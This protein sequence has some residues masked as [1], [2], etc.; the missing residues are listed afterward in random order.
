MPV[1]KEDVIS[2]YRFLLGREPAER[3][4]TQWLHIQSVSA[5]RDI[6]LSSPE[7]QGR[8]R[9]KMPSLKRDRLPLDIAPIVIEWETDP[10]T[11][12]RL[13]RYVTDT[14][15]ALGQTEPHWSVLSTDA[16]KAANIERTEAAFYASGKTDASRVVATLARHA[17]RTADLQRVVEYG[18]GVGRVTPYLAGHFN[19]V[20]GVDISES[21]LSLAQKA[22]SASGRRNIR[23]ALARAPDFGM[24]EPFD[25]WFSYIVLQHNPPPVI[26]L[27]LRRMF[28]MLAPGGV[29]IFQIPT[30]VPGYRFNVGKYLSAPKTGEIEVHCLPQPTVFQIAHDA[31]CEAL[32]VREDEAMDYPWLSNTFVFRKK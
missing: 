29:A 26:A 23:L 7:C 22:T 28:Q 2:G 9:A 10:D 1:T 8:M 19:E 18:C 3:E 6:F 4:V 5:L 15:A 31:G 16:F 12:G 24:A 14:W 11:Q 21:H 20:L 32:E 27:V 25:L 13:V 17:I 30:Y